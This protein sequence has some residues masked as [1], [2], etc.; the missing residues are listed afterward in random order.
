MELCPVVTCMYWKYS[1]EVLVKTCYF[2]LGYVK[3]NSA[4]VELLFLAQLHCLLIKQT[5]GVLEVNFKLA[6][7]QFRS[8]WQPTCVLSVHL[9]NCVAP[10][11]TPQKCFAEGGIK[12]GHIS[13]GFSN[14]V[15]IS[16]RR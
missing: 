2:T 5:V 13:H 7:D 3:L 10:Y 8:V 1:F 11:S 9:N 14:L 6:N 12:P 16:I 4:H 15:S